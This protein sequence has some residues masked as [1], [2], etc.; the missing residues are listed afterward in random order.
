MSG[1]VRETSDTLKPG[2][3]IGPKVPLARIVDD[4]APQWEVVAYVSQ[5]DITRIGST[6]TARFYPEQVTS[7]A[8]DI[9]IDRVERLNSSYV[10]EVILTTPN[11]GAIAATKDRQGRYRP[12]DPVFRVTGT[13]METSDLARQQDG[14]SQLRRGSL[15]IEASAKSMIARLYEAVV[16]G[17]I[18]EMAF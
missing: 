17:V 8:L 9:Q 11:G 13:V 7:P 5:R 4:Q 2:H 1:T 6:P 10:E 12:L 3:W 14:F 15:Q 16:S 18:R